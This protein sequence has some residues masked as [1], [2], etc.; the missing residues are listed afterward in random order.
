MAEKKKLTPAEQEKIKQQIADLQKA[1]EEQ[2]EAKGAEQAAEATEE[3]EEQ[4]AKT[5]ALFDRL[6]I[7]EE[8]WP[9][10]SAALAA[11]TEERTRAIVREE[12]AAEEEAEND[13]GSLGE[14]KDDPA[15][16]PV[17]QDKPPEEPPASKHWTEKKI[18]G[19]KKGEEE[20]PN[21]SS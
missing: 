17:K 5:A 16:P 18:F 11:G 21:A 14:L 3:V 10:L 2:E 9:V 15:A 8:D 1:L 4:R 13:K 6:G 19:S 7:T 20:P 12:L